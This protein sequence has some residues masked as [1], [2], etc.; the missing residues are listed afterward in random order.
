MKCFWCVCGEAFEGFLS[1]K[2]YP[3]LGKYIHIWPRDA[4]AVLGYKL[5]LLPTLA[6]ENLQNCAA[7]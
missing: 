4:K 7:A 2:V 5:L 6:K 1:H 3:W